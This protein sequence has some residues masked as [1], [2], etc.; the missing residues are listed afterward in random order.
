MGMEL[1]DG[2]D[3][4]PLVPRFDEGLSCDGTSTMSG[5]LQLGKR[6]ASFCFAFIAGSL[7]DWVQRFLTWGGLRP[8]HTPLLIDMLKVRRVCPKN[9]IV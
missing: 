7:R 2:T 6:F 8:P 3:G 4:I 1:D 5:G 9:M